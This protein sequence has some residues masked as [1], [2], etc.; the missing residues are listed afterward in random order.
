M[1]HS[2]SKMTHFIL[3]EAIS[4][5]AAD[6]ELNAIILFYNFLNEEWYI[7]TA[8]WVQLEFGAKTTLPPSQIVRNFECVSKLLFADLILYPLQIV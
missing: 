5:P 6:L 3:Q 8:L 1:V 2:V 7:C 4:P